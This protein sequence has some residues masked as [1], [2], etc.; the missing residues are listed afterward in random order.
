LTGVAKPGKSPEDVEQAL[1]KE[2]ERMQKEPVDANEL[3]K[4]KNQYAANN[5]RGIQSN[6]GLM[7]QLLLR[8]NIRGWETIN[9]D[10]RAVRQ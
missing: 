3:Q 2:I 9:T 1:Y 4:V 6:F 8:D 7:V 5:F 10:R